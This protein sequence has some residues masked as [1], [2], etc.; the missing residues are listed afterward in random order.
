[1]ENGSNQNQPGQL[2][3]PENS[4]NTPPSQA[5]NAQ[6]NNES[7]KIVQPIEQVP[8]PYTHEAPP[9]PTQTTSATNSSLST[10]VPT[11][12]TRSNEAVVARADLPQEQEVSPESNMSD[13]SFTYENPV[14]D[15]ISWSASEFIAHEKNNRWYVSLF[16]GTTVVALVVFLFTRDKI[17]TGMVVLVAIIFGIFGAR[18]PRTLSYAISSQGV[19]IGQKFYPYESFKSFSIVAEGAISSIVFMP[20]KRFV[21]GA[22]IYYPPEQEDQIVDILSTYLPHEERQLDVIDNLMRKVRF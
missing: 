9:P 14:S 12:T 21:P 6:Q 1:M 5:D 2:I 22:S 8:V 19:G 4:T 15:E 16:G 3:Q 17:S 20:I 11:N 7:T 13:P 10:D 18:K